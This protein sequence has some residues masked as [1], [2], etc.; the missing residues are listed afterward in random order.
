MQICWGSAH[1]QPIRIHIR[2]H[3][4]T[5]WAIFTI[6]RTHPCTTIR[7]SMF[8]TT[9]SN[10]IQ[11]IYKSNPFIAGSF[12]K[13]TVF[14]SR[15][16]WSRSVWRVSS[17]RISAVWDCSTAIRHKLRYRYTHHPSALFMSSETLNFFRSPHRISCPCWRGH[18]RMHWNWMSKSSQ[19]SQPW[20]LVHKSNKCSPPNA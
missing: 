16:I 8:L 9:R 5:S 19:S 1:R 12:S 4:L 18:Q 6:I 11:P 17:D 10:D 15:T 20:K 2:A 14:C 3:W 13:I 7:K